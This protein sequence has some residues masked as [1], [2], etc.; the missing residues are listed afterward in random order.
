MSNKKMSDSEK[1]K[2]K[3]IEI[4]K[5]DNFTCQMCGEKESKGRVFDVHH[6]L[7]HLGKKKWE[8]DNDDL[9]TLC[10]NC[11]FYISN[12]EGV[13]MYD[14]EGK[15]IAKS[16]QCFKCKGKGY[17]KEYAHHLDGIC[18]K[19]KGTGYS[20]KIPLRIIFETEKIIK[21]KLFFEKRLKRSTL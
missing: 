11:H 5:R 17:I 9:E 1:W 15:F 4:R 8:Y 20:R 21:L 13:P 14:T 7:Y 10:W 6:K 12:F 18:F 19:C 3:S 16:D 2:Q